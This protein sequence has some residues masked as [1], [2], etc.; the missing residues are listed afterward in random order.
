MGAE[1]AAR[2]SCW[3]EQLQIARVHFLMCCEKKLLPHRR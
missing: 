2:L 1:L 3:P